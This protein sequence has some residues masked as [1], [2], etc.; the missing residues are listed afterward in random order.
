M[1]TTRTPYDLLWK[2]IFTLFFEDFIKFF[3]PEEL[4]D[5]IDFTIPFE[6]LEQEFNKSFT[7]LR[8]SSKIADKVVRVTLKNGATKILF[9]HIEFQGKAEKMFTARV[10]DY[11]SHIRFNVNVDDITSLVLYTGRSRPI[12]HNLFEINHYGTK[13]SFFFNTYT[14]RE[15]LE[16]AL[17]TSDNPLSIAVLANLYVI[18]TPK[19]EKAVERFAYKKRLVEIALMKNFS[20]LKLRLML[21]FVK[22]LMVL[23]EDLE[24]D[25]DSFTD[26]K[27]GTM[28][29]DSIIEIVENAYFEE[30]VVPRLKTGDE[31]FA[32]DY[33]N[34]REALGKER[35]QEERK[36]SEAA[37][38][39]AEVKIEAER[40]KADAADAER[41][42]HIWNIRQ[43]M[44]WDAE[45][46]ADLLSEPLD[47]VQNVLKKG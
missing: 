42:K 36:K 32:A 35:L 8:P 27:F 23:P 19:R 18:R 25:F 13:M 30:F 6:S 44:G 2:Y 43:K 45:Q 20:P 39:R 24:K 47:Y 11:F 21:S 22:K 37:L 7:M 12:P 38:R 46:I 14:V 10:F 40:Q 26:L 5:A 34:F 33:L 4:Y 41:Q 16:A 9:I 28:Q 31:K 29:E 3:F 1:T 15:Q 17:I